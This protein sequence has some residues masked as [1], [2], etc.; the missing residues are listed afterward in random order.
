MASIRQL[1]SRIRSVGNTKQITKAMQM[2][3][4][5]KMRKIQDAPKATAPYTKAANE[6]LTYFGRQEITDNHPLFEVRQVNKRMII[7][8]AADKGLAGAYNF[9][10][11]KKYTKALRDDDELGV[12]NKTIT[13]GHRAAAFATRLKDVE[14]AGVYENMP[15]KPNGRDIRVIVDGAI[16]AFSCKEVDAV[17]IVYT[18][19]HSSFKQEATIRRVLPAGYVESDIDESVTDSKYEP[20]AEKLLDMIV[21]RLIEAR[22]YQAM[23]DAKAS[24]HS[25]R[26]VAMKNATDNAS[27]LKDDLTLEMNKAR[28]SAI[29]QEISEISGG[30]EAMNT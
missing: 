8:I 13:V 14:V 11:L 24:E 3:A 17:D 6:F 20:S 16:K 1:K 23:I 27:D 28:Q 21:Y 2:V 4:A 7:V 10:V 29:T 25:M 9:N 22:I 30:V 19:F 12:E 18:E 26:M 15:D 5:S